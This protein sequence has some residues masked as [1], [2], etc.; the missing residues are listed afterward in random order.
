MCYIKD[1]VNMFIVYG[2][3]REEEGDG[4]FKFVWN[5]VKV[6]FLLM[7]TNDNALNNRLKISYFTN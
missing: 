3:G 7:L 5:T 2:E 4:K 1:R 6:G